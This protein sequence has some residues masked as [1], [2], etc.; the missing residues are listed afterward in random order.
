M[1]DRN[2]NC[3]S[4]AL[5]NPLCDKVEADEAT[6][7][8]DREIIA[9][10][11]EHIFTESIDINMA[12]PGCDVSGRIDA[13]NFE[14]TGVDMYEALVSSNETITA[15]VRAALKTCMGPN[16]AMQCTLPD[17]VQRHTDIV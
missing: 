16:A 3:I 17:Y 7:A 5:H 12:E 9:R 1:T 13:L 15:I 2:P 14:A 11:R 8:Q 10:R 6:N 4:C